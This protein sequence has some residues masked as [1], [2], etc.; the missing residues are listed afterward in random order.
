MFNLKQRLNKILSEHT[1]K[2]VEEVE[3]DADR[4]NY[5]SGEEAAAYGLIDKVLE[6]RSDEVPSIT[7]TDSE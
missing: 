4:D 2:T 7:T 6:K 1:G 5:M 3:N